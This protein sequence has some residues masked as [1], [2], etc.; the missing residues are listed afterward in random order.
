M[1][2]TLEGIAPLSTWALTIGAAALMLCGFVAYGH[3][4]LV[5]QAYGEEMRGVRDPGTRATMLRWAVLLLAAGFLLWGISLDWTTWVLGL[6][7]ALAAAAAGAEVLARLS[8]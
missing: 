2:Q 8:G 1:L 6:L 7:G 4:M 5:H 3:A